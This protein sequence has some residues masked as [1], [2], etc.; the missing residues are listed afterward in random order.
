M[1]VLGVV[2]GATL[3]HA[4]PAAPTPMAPGQEHPR[5]PVVPVVVHPA[6]VKVGAAQP[7]TVGAVKP[8]R[9]GHAPLLPLALR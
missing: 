3:F 5:R 7:I 4:S 9:L 2:V 1:V 6:P 8:Q